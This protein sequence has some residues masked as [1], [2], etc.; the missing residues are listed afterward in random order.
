MSGSSERIH[1]ARTHPHRLAAGRDHCWQHGGPPPRLARPGRPGV[2]WFPAE[3]GAWPCR[4]ATALGGGPADL[5][6]DPALLG[7]PDDVASGDPP[8]ASRDHP[9][10]NAAGSGDGGSGCRGSACTRC[11][12]EHCLDYRRGARSDGRDRG[13][14]IAP[15]PSSSRFRD[16]AGREFGQRRYRAGDLCPRGRHRHRSCRADVHGGRWATRGL[17]GGWHHLGP[18]DGVGVIPGSSRAR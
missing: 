4:S 6:S 12:L 18:G 3:P 13:R 14:C 9:Y 16:A 5:P 8:L 2:G 10:R 17:A 7:K 11:S 1:H 15:G